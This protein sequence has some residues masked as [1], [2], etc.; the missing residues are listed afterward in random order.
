MIEGYKELNE[1]I[2]NTILTI[3]EVAIASKEQ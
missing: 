2:S 1:H 3:N